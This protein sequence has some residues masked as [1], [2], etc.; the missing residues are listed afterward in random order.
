MR[1]PQ[2]TMTFDEIGEIAGCRWIILLKYKELLPYGYE[3]GKI[4]MKAQTV[5]FVQ[6]KPE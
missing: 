5:L 1:K 4:S 3:V 2:L 6:K